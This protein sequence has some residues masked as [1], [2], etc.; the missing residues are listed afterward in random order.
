M[1]VRYVSLAGFL[2]LVVAASFI[3]AGFEAGEWYHVTMSQPSWT[4][5]H[6]LFGPIWALV[7]VFMALA[8]WKVWLTGHYSRLSTLAWWG[9]LL[10]LNITWSALFFGLHRPGWALPLLG[11]TIGIAIF[12]TRAF[13]RLSREATFLMVPYLVWIVFILVFNFAVWTTNGGF[14]QNLMS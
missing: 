3:G 6:W 9:L 2:L 7:Y 1:L 4:P 12:C 13:G 10:V 14:L 11:L 8:A 5:P